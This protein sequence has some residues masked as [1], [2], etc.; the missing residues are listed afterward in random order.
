MKLCTVQCL[1]AAELPWREPGKLSFDLS[2][3]KNLGSSIDNFAEDFKVRPHKPKHW[4]KA[5]ACGASVRNLC[6][7]LVPAQHMEVA[8]SH[9]LLY[10]PKLT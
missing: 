1:Q 4:C 3:L 9:F 2:G 10:R 5:H 8:T 6:L 7:T